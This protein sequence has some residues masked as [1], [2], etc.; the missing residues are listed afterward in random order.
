MI[1]L[2]THIQACARWYKASNGSVMLVHIGTGSSEF[3]KAVGL[4]E[5]NRFCESI[6]GNPDPHAGTDWIKSAFEKVSLVAKGVG[7]E[8]EFLLSTRSE[9]GFKVFA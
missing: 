3:E 6:K 7:K 8:P 5:I 4:D 9:P 2:Y 1:Y